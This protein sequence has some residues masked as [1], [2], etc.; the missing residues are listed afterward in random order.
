MAPNMV[1]LPTIKY[2]DIVQGSPSA[3]AELFKAASTDGFFQLDLKDSAAQVDA[4]NALA[5]VYKVGE[6]YFAQPTDVKEKDRR[7]GDS[8]DRGYAPDIRLSFHL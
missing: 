4:L 7:I 1:D 5:A 6:G 3:A 2:D 8:T